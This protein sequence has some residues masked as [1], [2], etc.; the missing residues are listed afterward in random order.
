MNVLVV[1]AHPNPTSFSSSLYQLV[2]T[3]FRQKGD[4]VD[5]LDLYNDNFNPC[6]SQ[7]EWIAYMTKNNGVGKEPYIEQLQWAEALILI[8]PTWWMGPPAILKGWFD[9]IWL[10]GV[11]ANYGEGK[12]KAGLTTIKK[13]MVVTTQGSSWLRMMMIGNPPKRML[14][15]SL[16]CCTKARIQW[17]AM[18][19][20]DKA[21]QLQRKA[22][23]KKIKKAVQQF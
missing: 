14:S 13:I 16:K 17:L 15:L 21:T 7:Q 22:F 1:Y 11:A 9:R 5:C 20:M 12:L 4:R 18:Y 2:C 10:P 19:S 3:E 6:L 8:Y 23:L